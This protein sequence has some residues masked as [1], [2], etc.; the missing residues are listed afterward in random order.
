MGSTTESEQNDYEAF[1]KEVVVPRGVVRDFLS[2]LARGGDLYT[3]LTELMIYSHDN[4]H[5]AV[6]SE[7]RNDILKKICDTKTVT[8]DDFKDYV[9]AHR[10]MDPECF[11]QFLDTLERRNPLL[12]KIRDFHQMEVLEYRSKYQE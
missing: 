12:M 11:K 2:V 10:S 1:R 7:Y 3:A 8:Q 6:F 5:G 9:F 4:V